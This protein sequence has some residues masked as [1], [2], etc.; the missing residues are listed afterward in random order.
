MTKTVSAAAASWTTVRP[1]GVNCADSDFRGFLDINLGINV[2]NYTYSL[3]CTDCTSPNA[4]SSPSPSLSQPPHAVHEP[5][6]RN[7]DWCIGDSDAGGAVNCQAEYVATYP[8]RLINAPSRTRSFPSVGPCGTPSR[9]CRQLAA[10]LG[11][12]PSPSSASL[13][14]AWNR[15]SEFRAAPPGGIQRIHPKPA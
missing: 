1:I 15:W 7:I 9:R 6:N 5:W 2:T 10:R 11:H 4:F 3:T 13:A 12:Q 14:T 8:E